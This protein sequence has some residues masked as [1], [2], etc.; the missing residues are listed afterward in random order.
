MGV[1]MATA[2]AIASGKR[3]INAGVSG[4]VVLLTVLPRVPAVLPAVRP[5]A[6][7]IV[8][9]APFQIGLLGI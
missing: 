2:A 4:V 7:K 5:L 3:E 1:S 9:S 6:L 8:L